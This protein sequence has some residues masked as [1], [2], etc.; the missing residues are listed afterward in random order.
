MKPKTR[1]VA[2]VQCRCGKVTDSRHVSSAFHSHYDIKV[3]GETPFICTRAL[4]GAEVWHLQLPWEIDRLSIT[5]SA[6][7]LLTGLFCQWQWPGCWIRVNGPVRRLLARVPGAVTP[8]GALTS[9][10]SL[11]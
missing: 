7:G 8:H 6:K 5:A 2:W 11:L 1:N 3:T 9:S 10:C 4:S